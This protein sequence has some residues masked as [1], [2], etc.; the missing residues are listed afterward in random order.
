MDF[1]KRLAEMPKIKFTAEA[2]RRRG[3]KEAFKPQ[4]DADE[5]RFLTEGNK[6]DEEGGDVNHTMD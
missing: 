6:G 3:A 4:M 2:Q 5:R 1:V